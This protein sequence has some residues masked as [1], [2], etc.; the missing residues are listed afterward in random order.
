ML[1]W[2]CVVKTI[3]GRDGGEVTEV[4]VGVILKTRQV[5]DVWRDLFPA[6]S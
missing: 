1:G 4:D 5:K 6:T 3:K 2:Q